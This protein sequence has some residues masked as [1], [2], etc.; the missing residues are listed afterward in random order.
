MQGCSGNT[1]DD[2]NY[3]VY[4]F[5]QACLLGTGLGLIAG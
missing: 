4:R 1:S 5:V 2:S 3:L